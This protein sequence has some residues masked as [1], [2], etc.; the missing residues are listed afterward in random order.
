MGTD[1]TFE[2]QPIAC[3]LSGSDQG[4]RMREWQ[5]LL[6]QGTG[7]EPVPDGIRVTLPAALA[8]PVAELAA[9]EQRCCP[10][11]RFTLVFDGGDLQLTM[12]APAEAAPLL[13][14]L[15]DAP[16]DESVPSPASYPA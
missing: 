4:Q 13:T 6:A 3:T 10:F 2:L 7:R 14:A 11:F 15:A 8:G 5:D 12:Q 9:A 16:A 1:Q